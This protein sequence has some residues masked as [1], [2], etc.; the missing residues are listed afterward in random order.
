MAK[1]DWSNP[2]LRHLGQR[3]PP[4]VMGSKMRNAKVV[5][6]VIDS[7]GDLLSANARRAVADKVKGKRGQW[8]LMRM[9]VLSPRARDV[10][11]PAIKIDLV[12]RNASDFANPLPSNQAELDHCLTTLRDLI[13]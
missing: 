8:H 12:H 4:K 10:P 2:K 6:V 9:A 3:R 1:D 5:L 13:Q 11:Y 7:L